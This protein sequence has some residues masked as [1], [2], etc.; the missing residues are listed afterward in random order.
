MSAQTAGILASHI[1]STLDKRERPEREHIHREIRFKRAHAI[2]QSGIKFQER[3]HLAE[4]FI[5]RTYIKL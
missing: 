3:T 4:L 2:G 1:I 5:A